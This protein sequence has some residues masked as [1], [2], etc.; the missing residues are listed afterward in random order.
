[1]MNFSWNIPNTNMTKLYVS[2]IPMD[3]GE[4][5]LRQLFLEHELTCTEVSIKRGGY[6]FVN[7]LDQST[8]DRAIDV[9]N[10][11]TF[12]DSTLIIEPFLTICEKKKSL[13]SNLDDSPLD[14]FGNTCGSFKVVISGVPAE[15]GLQ[16]LE[17]FLEQYGRVLQTE[18]LVGK[19]ADSKSILI[20]YEIL[21]Q[22]QK[23]VLGLNGIEFQDTNLCAEMV[24][25]T[26][27]SMCG[28][29]RP[30]GP[31]L[32]YAGPTAQA[33]QINYTLAILVEN[34]MVR[35]ILGSR[36]STIRHIIQET[37]ARIDIHRK[38]KVGC[39]AK[40]VTIY[41]KPDNC[42]KACKRILEVIQQEANNTTVGEVVLKILAHN[43]L[44]GRVI[45]KRG[46]NI[47]NI[48]YEQGTKITIS[49]IRDIDNHDSERII[50]I[51]GSLD[52]VAQCESVISA[53]LRQ[54]YENDLQATST[55]ILFPGLQ[56]IGIMPPIE[57]G[58]SSFPHG[59]YPRLGRYSTIYSAA[60][61]TISQGAGDRRETTYIHL[62]CEVV[63]AIIGTKGC[64]IQNIIRLSRASIKI[65]P[66]KHDYDADKTD[67]VRKATIV[68]NA[69]SQ[70]KAQ[71]LFFDRIREEGFVSGDARLTVEMCVPSSKAGKIIGISGFNIRE[72]QRVTGT[73]IKLYES[74]DK[75]TKDEVAVYINGNFFGIQSA[76]R[77]I[78]A[79][80]LQASISPS[81]T[82][83]QR[84]P[85]QKGPPQPAFQ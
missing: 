12:M 81:S 21:Q 85:M 6:A 40:I 62:P 3:A 22:A 29:F 28:R 66:L 61:R 64:N 27:R 1:M 44:I 84:A 33:Q 80:V 52:N 13:G 31:G 39:L 43:S 83:Q 51:R 41:G 77:L 23:A 37:R 9:L 25:K 14:Q 54:S 76:Q 74:S 16:D 15:A 47:K 11:I 63:G 7:C 19:D 65:A 50:T 20:T 32:E 34:D 71:Y 69:E 24:D 72:L 38:G 82:R 55:Q 46:I 4:S 30:L 10:G 2:N 58:A 26:M 56:L 17:P 49:S 53:Q 35:A 8:A 5:D 68:G 57:N 36:G 42:T 48:M 60:K 73:T 45:G 67:A 79:I 59:I 78:R 18:Q 75:T 70:W